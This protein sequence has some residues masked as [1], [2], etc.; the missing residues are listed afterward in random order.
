[1]KVMLVS[2][3]RSAAT[4]G[5]AINVG[6]AL[7]TDAL[8]GQLAEYGNDVDAVDF[9]PGRANGDGPRLEVRGFRQLFR[10]VRQHDAV[11]IGGGTMIQV[12]SD[13]LLRGSLMRLCAA[14]SV[15]G[16][17]SRVPVFYF[18][19]GC[20][21]LT[22][23]LARVGYRLALWRRRVWVRDAGSARRLH[24][25]FGSEPLTAADAALLLETKTADA[26]EPVAGSIAIAPNRRDGP[27]LTRSWIQS[28]E[29]SPSQIRL[30]PMSY[31]D[32]DDLDLVSQ[33]S[34]T[35]MRTISPVAGWQAVLD[36]FAT[37]ETVLASRMHALYIA[38]LLDIPMVAIGSSSKVV[39]FA[40]E[41]GVPRLDSFEDYVPGDER[42]ASAE[43]VLEAKARVAR[44]AEQLGVLL[45][46]LPVGRA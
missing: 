28:L 38:L 16:W 3:D 46:G 41:F 14:V 6:D 43:A 21:P 20:D 18:A 22:S 40:D 32:I 35:M 37:S 4:G 24:Q 36:V 19:V 2:A 44:G 29:R 17:L 9:G 1:M 30:V 26:S 15:A 25:Y 31:G 7:L 33:D 27:Q 42:R 12:D 13:H 23:R 10:E 39:A 11:V 45:G 8:M 5:H 34:L